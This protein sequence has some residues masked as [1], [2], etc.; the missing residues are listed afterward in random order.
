[1]RYFD[2]SSWQGILLSVLA[3]AR[4]QLSTAADSGAQAGAK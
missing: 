2:F 1:M 4:S 3:L